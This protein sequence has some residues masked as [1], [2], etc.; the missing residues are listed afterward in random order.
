MAKAAVANC[1]GVGKGFVTHLLRDR[2]HDPFPVRPTLYL[3]LWA[4]P[5]RAISSVENVEYIT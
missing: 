4:C 2:M 1:V 3:L 5:S